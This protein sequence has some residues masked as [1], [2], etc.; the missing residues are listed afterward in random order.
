MRIR[1]TEAA[2]AFG[3]AGAGVLAAAILYRLRRGRRDEC[4]NPGTAARREGEGEIRSSGPEGMRSKVRREWSRVDEASDESFP[5][6][7]PPA[8]W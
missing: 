1:R 3:I 8:T 7:D 2:T 4:C 6:S 5:A